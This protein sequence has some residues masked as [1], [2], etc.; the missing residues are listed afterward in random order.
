MRLMMKATAALENGVR[1]VY[2][3]ASN[4]GVDQQGE[5]ILASALKESAD[6]F[7]KFGNID[8]DHYTM[9]GAKAG[10]PDYQSYEIGQP[11]AVEFDG[12]TT[13]VKARLYEG[14]T[15]LAARANEVWAS[16]TELN[17]PARWYP[18]VG[19]AILQ[20]STEVDPVTGATCVVIEKVRWT[21]VGI[22]RTP[23]NQHLATLSSTPIGSFSKT[24]VASQGTDHAQ[25]AGGGA[26]GKQ[27]IDGKRKRL[28]DY[29]Q[30]KA[31]LCGALMKGDC[32]DQSISGMVE[33]GMKNFDIGKEQCHQWTFQVMQDLKKHIHC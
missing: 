30:F 32:A 17:P 25:L 31:A 3:E 14:D 23:V 1:Y 15:P 33:Y 4:E 5:R 26:L 6:L 11:V 18:S 22:S 13:M 16:L 29:S 12:E 8:I 21:N 10:I 2:F 20:K 19:G 27:S 7:L 24:L 9:I 28:A